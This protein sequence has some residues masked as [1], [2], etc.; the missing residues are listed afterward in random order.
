MEFIMKNFYKLLIP[1]CVFVISDLNAMNLDSRAFNLSH[2][3]AEFKFKE[4]S[5]DF[6]DILNSI[7]E[8]KEDASVLNDVKK[9]KDKLDYEEENS[10]STANSSNSI[11]GLKVREV[12]KILEVVPV[13]AHTEAIE[14]AIAQLKRKLIDSVKSLLKYSEDLPSNSSDCE[15][16]Y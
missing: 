10:D 13:E 5:A 9:I 16:S 3:I 6:K 11:F 14:L 7:I 8:E 2:K 4:K 12:E 1:F 15:N